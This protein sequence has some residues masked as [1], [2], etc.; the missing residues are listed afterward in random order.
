VSCFVAPHYDAYFYECAHGH[1]SASFELTLNLST[2]FETFR[3]P[4]R[5]HRVGVWRWRLASQMRMIMLP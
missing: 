1:G 3:A 2:R 4:S 5:R